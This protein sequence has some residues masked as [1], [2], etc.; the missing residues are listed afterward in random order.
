MS[1]K[2]DEPVLASWGCFL[3]GMA[4]IFW[5]LA[6]P[7][8]KNPIPVIDVSFWAGDSA[9]DGVS[10]AQEGKTLACKDPQFD[11]F[12]CLTYEDLQKIY[13]TLLECKDWPK[14]QLASDRDLRHFKKMNPE[15]YHYVR[16][17]IEQRESVQ[18][19]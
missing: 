7:G 5:V 9:K 13:D 11:Q 8:C 16:A 4:I 2:Q 6:L 17:R 10:R 14:S 18:S 15:V 19:D 12:V 3:L 1:F